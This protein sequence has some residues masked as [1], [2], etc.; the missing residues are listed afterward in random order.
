MKVSKKRKDREVIS[1]LKKSGLGLIV[2]ISWSWI[3]PQIS[4]AEFTNL[5]INGNF[6]SE[7]LSAWRQNSTDAV[8]EWKVVGG[9]VGPVG[10]HTLDYGNFLKLKDDVSTPSYSV[11]SQRIDLERV[12]L[13]SLNYRFSFDYFYTDNDIIFIEFCV[14]HDCNSD[15]G[16]HCSGHS[17]SHYSDPP[18]F[19]T[20]HWEGTGLLESTDACVDVKIYSQNY[21]DS[22]SNSG[23]D[24]AM[25]EFDVGIP[26]LKGDVNNSGIVDAVDVVH[27]L[28]ALAEHST[29]EQ[30]YLNVDVDGD[31]KF[32]L[33]E[34]I[35]ILKQAKK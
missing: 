13:N 21:D 1:N 27:S 30:I 9:E 28:G 19:Y 4:T 29:T 33:P 18:P 24:N 23:V 32:S 26:V 35:F 15:A 6:D 3:F 10:L 25:V 16:W 22:Y 11:I 8:T 34:V 5:L 12:N 20:D 2:S 17:T 31:D 14:P 7:D